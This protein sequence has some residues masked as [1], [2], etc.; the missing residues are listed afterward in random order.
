M[1][2]QFLAKRWYADIYEQQENQTDDVDFLL[3]QISGAPKKILEAACGGGRL[4][5]PLAKAGHIAYGFDSDEFMLKKCIAKARGLLNLNCR[6]ADAV[7]DNWGEGFDVVVLGGNILINIESEMDYIKAQRLFLKKAAGALRPGGSLY[8]DFNANTWTESWHEPGENVIFEGYDD[9]GTFGRYIKFNE[10][11][12]NP[13]Q[14]STF[15]RKTELTAKNGESAVFEREASKYFP[16]LA[17]VKSWL[18]EY[19]L[20]ISRAFGGYD[21]RPLTDESNRAVIF[22][23]KL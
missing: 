11:Y 10:R 21:G 13:T 23:V 19:G 9:L 2:M 15:K 3:S 20:E 16:R 14:T 1:D 18:C 12:D 6:K 4:L 22:A 17:E 7:A 5:V 8:L